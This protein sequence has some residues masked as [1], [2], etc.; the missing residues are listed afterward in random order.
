LVLAGNDLY[1]DI[2]AS[3]LSLFDAENFNRT[4]KKSSEPI[5]WLTAG[6]SVALLR[7]AGEAVPA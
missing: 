2:D 3:E 5:S 4:S 6:V 7:Y 1:K